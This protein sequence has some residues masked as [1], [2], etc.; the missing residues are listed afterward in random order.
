MGPRASTSQNNEY[1]TLLKD[2]EVV[3]QIDCDGLFYLKNT[4]NG[5]DYLLREFTFN[6]KK[7]FERYV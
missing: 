1:N 4:S 5:G 3:K 6:D 2:Y 7:E